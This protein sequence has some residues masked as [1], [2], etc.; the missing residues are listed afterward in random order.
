MKNKKTPLVIAILFSGAFIGSLFGEL[1]SRF[2]S[3]GTI[4]KVFFESVLIG[5]KE[6]LKLDL[7]FFYIVFGG[8]LKINFFALL[9]LLIASIFAYR[10]K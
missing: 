5:I 2:L 3:E 7:Y 9:G 10:I 6:P 1:C 8:G 4:K